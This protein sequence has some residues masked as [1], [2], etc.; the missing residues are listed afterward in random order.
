MGSNDHIDFELN[1]RIEN[2]RDLGF[3]DEKEKEL[4]IALFVVDHG[5]AS[6][7]PKQ[8][9]VWDTAISPILAKP[10]SAEERFQD[11]LEQDRADEA[12][13]GPFR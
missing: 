9:Y 11:A 8:K 3:F 6:L 1:N 13:N 10:Q 4:G 12:R 2:A 7:S 5:I